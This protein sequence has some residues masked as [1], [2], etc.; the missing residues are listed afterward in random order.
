MIS[1]FIILLVFFVI[2]YFVLIFLFVLGL[3]K[4]KINKSKNTQR[5]TVV[6]PFRNEA[7]NLPQLLDS[8]QSQSLEEF[9]L[10]LIDDH[11]DDRSVEIL[12]SFNFREGIA[13]NLII[14]WPGSGKK[15]ALKFAI[16]KSG[17]NQIVSTDAD[18]VF[19]KDWLKIFQ[20][21]FNSDNT[22]IIGG[23]SI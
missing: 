1:C 5:I 6:I 9:D 21:N 13:F 16:E 10:I 19:S 22:F 11:S 12:K 2:L 4:P 8:I 18:C 15:H 20:Q 14:D 17:S 23:V 7:K 3:F